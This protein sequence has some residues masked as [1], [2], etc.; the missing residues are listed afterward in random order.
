MGFNEIL[1]C[2]IFAYTLLIAFAVLL[3]II[4]K[5]YKENKSAAK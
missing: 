2:L 4:Y 1:Y 3:P 5:N